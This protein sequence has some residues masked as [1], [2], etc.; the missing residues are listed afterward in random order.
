M[1]PREKTRMGMELGVLSAL[2]ALLCWGFGDF[3]IQKTT[4][5]IG[6]WETLFIICLFG[7]IILTPTVFSSLPELFSFSNKGLWVLC[8]ASAIYF[9][10]SLVNFEA[11]KDGKIAIVEPVLSLEVPLSAFFAFLFM[12]E[13]LAWPELALISIIMTGIVMVSLQSAGLSRRTIVEKGVV[14]ALFAAFLM[15]FQNVSIGAAS[16]VT[17]PFLAIWFGNVFITVA[18][19]TYLLVKRNVSDVCTD[20]VRHP[21]LVCAIGTLDNLAWIF[22][23]LAMKLAPVAIAVALSESYIAIGVLLGVLVN[24]ELLA[25]HQ[26]I[27]IGVTILGAVLLAT[28]TG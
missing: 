5:K 7:T 17:T 22:F 14:V 4:R 23:A 2:G 26:K 9:V 3:F 25:S 20:F 11:L 27:G 28:I 21:N 13:R 12:N 24:K 15:G 6:D 18:C 8:G 1:E 16:R 19:A 10:T